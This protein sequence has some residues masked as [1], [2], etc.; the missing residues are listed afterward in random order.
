M[1]DAPTLQQAEQDTLAEI[2]TWIQEVVEGR[3]ASIAQMV[4]S[5]V[6]GFIPY[7]GQAIDVY[8]ILR[9]LWMLT[10]NPGD[11]EHWISLV[12]SLVAIIPGFGDAIKNAFIM[13]RSGKRMGR[14]LDSLPN[15]LR[16]NVDTWF[17]T[18]D[19]ATYTQ[20]TK[21]NVTG[22]IN[23]MIEVLERRATQYILDRKGLQALVA[24]LRQIGDAASRQVDA[25][26]AELRSLHTA[27]LRDPLPSTA[28]SAPISSGAIRIPTPGTSSSGAV[29]QTSAGTP[30]PASGSATATKRQ[31][32]RSPGPKS[33]TGAS[34][35]H[36]ADYYYVRRQ[37]SRG[38]VNHKGVLYEMH[39]PGHTGIDHV[40][41]GRRLPNGYRISDTKGTSGPM[42]KLET[43][44][45]VFEALEY[46]IDAYLGEEDESKA[47]GA[48]NHR[49]TKSGVQMSH[50]WIAERIGDAKLTDPH[51]PKLVP[52]IKKW[53]DSEF[54]LG[55]ESVVNDE[56]GLSKT[57]VKCPYDR[58]II[59]VVGPNHNLH[60]RARGPATGRC[61][62]SAASH[63]IATEFILP[64]SL[65]PK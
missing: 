31:S 6:L 4:V 15:Y 12:L 54:K 29:R 13:M 63:Q 28:A 36:I 42:H 51:A 8:N 47:R 22:I 20:Q 40:W 58:S 21:N 3:G 23:G 48:V 33:R 7:V 34:G 1:S 37:G 27:A 61:G 2:L 25:A 59:T 32:D 30:T 44:R 45:A 62:K 35:E 52:A 16:G 39:Q 5:V 14:I 57:L 60:D 50:M 43:A 46:G 10:K 24:R 64:N 56:G 11:T 18:L 38:K 41:Y 17:R 65:L 19:W 53:E 26:M 49:E 55:A 9:S